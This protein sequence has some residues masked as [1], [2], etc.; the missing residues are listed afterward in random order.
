M[1]LHI[2]PQADRVE[3]LKARLTAQIA[4]AIATHGPDFAGYALVTW[5][6]RGGARTSY[7]TQAGPVS[8]T[9][10][11]VFAQD[12]LS[13]HVTIELSRQLALDEAEGD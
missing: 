8:H 12:A 5:D 11:P 13:R 3:E 4:A 9:L 2:S 7:D 6:M 10:M 1:I